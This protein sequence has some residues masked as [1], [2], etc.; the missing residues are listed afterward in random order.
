Y[1]LLIL[2]NPHTTI[3]NMSND[4]SSTCDCHG[5]YSSRELDLI[6]NEQDIKKTLFWKYFLWGHILQ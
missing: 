2:I 4:P 6:V 1:I 5:L 3:Y